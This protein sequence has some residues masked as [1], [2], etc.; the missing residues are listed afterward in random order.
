MQK[1]TLIKEIIKMEWTMFSNVNNISGKA[2]CQE[3]PETFKIMRISQ[4]NVWT[5]EILTSYL[6]DLKNAHVEGKNLMTEKYARMMEFSQPIEYEQIKDRLMVIPEE[7]KMHIDTIVEINMLWNEALVEQYP[8]LKAKGR[9]N[10]S[11]EDTAYDTSIET[12]MKGELAT[13]SI[14]TIELLNSYTCE[15]ANKGNNLSEEILLNTVKFYGYKSLKQ[16]DE[17]IREKDNKYLNS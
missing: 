9:K 2:S 6:V 17:K 5:D 4:I 11:S 7:T 16:A 1:E 10:R 15:Q 12:Y 13:Y 14:K 8:N 3:D